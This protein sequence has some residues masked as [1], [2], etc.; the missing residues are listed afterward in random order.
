MMCSV[1]SI[2]LLSFVAQ[3]YAQEDYFDQLMNMIREDEKPEFMNTAMFDELLNSVKGSVSRAIFSIPAP[4][5]DTSY[6]IS[7]KRICVYGDLSL[8]HI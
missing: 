5:N 6:T 2:I 4:A 3:A 7:G 8:I 1:T